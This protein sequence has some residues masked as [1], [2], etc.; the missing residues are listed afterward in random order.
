MVRVAVPLLFLL[1]IVGMCVGMALYLPGMRFD[2]VCL[3]THAPRTLVIYGYV[4]AECHIYLQYINASYL[5]QSILGYLSN[6][7][8]SLDSI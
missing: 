3:V 5:A 6:H 8:L 1:E 4:S 7:P 2:A